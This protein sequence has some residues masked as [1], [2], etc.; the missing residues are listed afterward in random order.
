MKT[1]SPCAAIRA[2]RSLNLLED[3]TADHDSILK[4]RLF[5]R[6]LMRWAAGLLAILGLF[7]CGGCETPT[8]KMVPKDW[9]GQTP[10]ALAS[11]DVVK[12]SFAGA[13][14]LNGVQKIRADGKISIP[15]LGEVDAAGKRL[16]QFQ[17]ELARLYK[18][19]LKNNEVTVTLE[20][21]VIPIYVSG[22]VL[23]PG[24]VALD[25][26]M[27]V[28]DAIMESGG[29]VNDVANPS[30]VVLIRNTNGQQVTQTLDLSPALKGR[31]TAAVY[32]KGYD[33]IYVPKLWN[34]IQ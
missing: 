29:F 19:Q 33:A 17:D 31:P 22:A 10:G 5:S 8:G 23:R 18:S 6:N 7:F 13:P 30:R 15:L 3:Q 27:T 20:S 16:G 25:R 21:S 4:E 9:A 11:G 32:V 12:L 1:A 2:P 26:S 28:F 24:K 34:A 14:E